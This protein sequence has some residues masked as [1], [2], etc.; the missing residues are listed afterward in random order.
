MA[1]CKFCGVPFQ[2]GSSDG[3]WVPL[4]PL[5]DEGDLP[6]TYQDE[7]GK[8]RSEHRSICVGFGP[9]VRVARLARPIEAG[10]V[11][12]QTFFVDQSTGEILNQRR[13]RRKRRR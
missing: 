6:R 9:A 13:S 5:G 7:N 1:L 10:D 12:A 2:W 8:L 4:V 3:K 11:L